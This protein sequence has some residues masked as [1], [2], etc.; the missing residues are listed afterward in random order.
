MCYII[1]L[2]WNSNG[3]PS[4]YHGRRASP[5]HSAPHQQAVRKT[6]TGVGGKLI[7]VEPYRILTWKCCR[8]LKEDIREVNRWWPLTS[9]GAFVCVCRARWLL[10]ARRWWWT[11]WML[12][13]RLFSEPASVWLMHGASELHS[14]P[15]HL[16][17]RNLNPAK[18]PEL[19]SVLALLGTFL[20]VYK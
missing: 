14:P 4:G 9:Q 11:E 5:S 16:L 3:L 12:L 8:T 2:E 13:L 15:G 19:S 10:A 17:S 7:F 20:G 18:H 1:N 6:D